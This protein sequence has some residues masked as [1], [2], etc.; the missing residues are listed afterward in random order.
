VRSKP[1]AVGI[2]QQSWWLDAVAPGRWDAVEVRGDDGELMAWMPYVVRH[3]KFG[4]KII[5]MPPLTLSLN[6][7]VGE[8]ASDMPRKQQAHYQ[9]MLG[10]LA[11]ALPEADLIRQRFDHLV[12]TALPFGQRGYLLRQ[13]YSYRINDLSD[14]EQLWAALSSSR[15]RQ[16]RNAG[17]QIE[18]SATDDV[19]IFLRLNRLT[20]ERQG[21]SPPYRDDVVR[22]VD[23]ACRA[24]NAREILIATDPSGAVHS[25]GYCV[26]DSYATYALMSGDDPDHRQ[27]GAGSL[28]R[29]EEIRRSAARSQ[30]FDFEGGTKPSLQ[31]FV[32][33][34]GAE[35]SPNVVVVKETLRWRTLDLAR[36][37][38]RAGASMVANVKKGLGRRT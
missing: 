27:S 11:D 38:A 4:L 20:Y 28:L 1:A 24:N 18:V 29:W 22:R 34:F 10:A 25:A 8:T 9:A 19:G 5:D 13:A 3:D 17:K 15:R 36:A 33:S 14:E 31:R 7:W 32:S 26:F 35:L 16:I 6:P 21:M 2:F 23:D 37:H 30:T 12:P